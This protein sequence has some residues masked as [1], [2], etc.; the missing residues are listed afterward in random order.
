MTGN[1]ATASANAEQIEA[2]NGIVGAKWV[3]NQDRLDRILAPF[4]KALLEVAAPKPGEHALDIGCG[5][6]ATTLELARQVGREGRVMGI[7]ISGPMVAR[8]RDRAGMLGL[9]PVFEVA[10]ASSYPFEP[11]SFDLLM[12]RFGVMFFDNPPSAFANL[13]RG[14]KPGARLAFICWRALG[15]NDWVKVP[16]AAALA[17]VQPPAPTPPGTPGPFAFA[18]RS[19]VLSIL[20]RAGFSSIAIEPFDAPM[21]IGTPEGGIEEAL[22]QSIEIGPIARLIADAPEDVRARARDAVREALLKH[23]TE[24]GIALGGAAWIVTARA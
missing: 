12:S 11:G 18:D 20:E 16:L 15:E 14:M 24:S 8:A 6:G 7:D 23:R 3:A 1:P 22:T 19:H 17:H 5:C 21:A 2:W 9:S 13:R 4:G 10:D